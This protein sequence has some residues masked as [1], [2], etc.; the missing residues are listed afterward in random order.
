[1]R[2]SQRALHARATRFRNAFVQPGRPELIDHLGEVIAPIE[3]TDCFSK[4]GSQVLPP[5]V[6]FQTPPATAPK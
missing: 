3:E 6:V 1:V 2:L 4:R 5:S